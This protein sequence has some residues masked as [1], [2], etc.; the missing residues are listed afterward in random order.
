MRFF[1]I[2]VV[3]ALLSCIALLF[4]NCSNLTSINSEDKPSISPETSIVNK[5]NEKRFKVVWLEPHSINEGVVQRKKPL[6]SQD[7]DLFVYKMKNL[8]VEK[9]VTAYSEYLGYYFYSPS[10]LMKNNFPEALYNHKLS[11]DTFFI[12]ALLSAAQKYE[13]DVILGL[14]PFKDKYVIHRLTGDLKIDRSNGTNN[15]FSQNNIAELNKQILLNQIMVTDLLNKYGMN[16][17]LK[18]FYLVQEPHCLDV[19]MNYFGP[20]AEYIKS[21]RSDLKVM[22]SP[23][24]DAE[25]CFT[26]LASSELDYIQDMKAFLINAKSR[27]LDIIAYQDSV[28]AGYQSGSLQ[29]ISY[30][31]ELLNQHLSYSA[32]GEG[33]NHFNDIGRIARIQ[34]LSNLSFRLLQDAHL[35]TG[36]DFWVN[37]ELWRMD[38][39]CNGEV[40]YYGCNYGSD[41]FLNQLDSWYP[42]TKTLMLN[43]GFTQFSFPDLEMEILKEGNLVDKPAFENAKQFTQSYVNFVEIE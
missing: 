10:A 38:G 43:E 37:T 27:G 12:D 11:D 33:K 17:S 32:D 31:G 3:L 8:G 29:F 21:Q 36:V 39:V 7:I 25:L 20:I 18:G 35:D 6:T 2:G 13:I 26:S 34:Y 41:T 19:G 14:S 5:L 30:Q 42:F 4:Q 24:A 28:G 1:K 40:N 15:G 16:S 9:L 22:I 23:N